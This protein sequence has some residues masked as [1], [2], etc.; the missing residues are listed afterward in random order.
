MTAFP[1][2]CHLLSPEAT[3]WIVLSSRFVKKGDGWGVVDLGSNLPAGTSLELLALGVTGDSRDMNTFFMA[4]GAIKSGPPTSRYLSEDITGAT[5]VA[6]LSLNGVDWN[7]PLKLPLPGDVSEATATSVAFCGPDTPAPGVIAVGYGYL[8]DDALGTRMVGLVWH[9]TDNGATWKVISDNTFAEAG[10]NISARFVASDGKSI[11]VV[12]Q[13]DAMTGKTVEGN[14]EQSTALWYLETDGSW[15]RG[16]DGSSNNGLVSSIA[17]ALFAVQGGGFAEATERYDTGSGS[18]DPGADS[19][20]GNPDV[21][22]R[23]TADGGK[24]WNLINGNVPGID[25]AALIDGI[26]VTGATLGFVGVDKSG[27]GMS[28]AVDASKTQ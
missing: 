7:P 14:P 3:P 5:P 16:T 23:G 21:V 13:A 15:T 17:T 27:R 9:S 1:R 6:M 11:M 12:G 10:R 18:T 22:L 26:Y 28:W 8:G 24:T 2:V 4:V 25:Q 19:V 20:I